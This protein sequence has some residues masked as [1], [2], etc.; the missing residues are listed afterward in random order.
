VSGRLR[1]A[2]IG[3]SR[4]PIKEPFAGGL[5][6]HVWT[7][8]RGLTARG[9]EVHLF[10][11]DGSDETV[12]AG[13]LTVLPVTVS[14]AAANDVS[15]PPRSWL[16]DHN[17]YLSLMLG[18]S[19]D[20][21]GPFD[22]VHNH[23]LHFLPIAMA[24]AV[25]PPMITTLHTPP[26]PWLESA[27]QVAGPCPVTFAAVSAHTAESWRHVAPRVHVVRNGV[28][29]DRW[30]PG[31][32]GGPLVWT[33]R[34]VP[35]KGPHLAIQ[36]A[37]LAGH[38]LVLA[39]PIADRD[40][41]ER[42]VAPLLGG[43]VRHAGHLSQE[44][45]RRL[46]GG[47]SACLVTPC[48]DEPYGLVV[49]EALACGTPVLAFR[50]GGIP[51]IVDRWCARLVPPGDVEALAAAIPEVVRLPRDAARRRAVEECSLHRMIEDYERL[52]LSAAAA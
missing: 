44:E 45:L 39:G 4:H 46:V 5:E 18:L 12:A 29:T 11:A 38:P 48:W 1:V 10:S 43:S 17:A 36:A 51:E 9:H 37:R 40:Y 13:V 8:A 42:A 15:M 47:A 2:L 28:D 34:M 6:A 23:S 32:G 20:R 24:P 25:A 27:V 22:V 35:E 50:R 7:L 19:R 31:A 33:G 52:Y 16:E 21:Y 41:Y 30:T 3:S 14:G 26:T 49:A